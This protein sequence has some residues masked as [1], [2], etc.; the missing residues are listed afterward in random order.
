MWLRRRG[1]FSVDAD[2]TTSPSLAFVADT[3]DLCKIF[4]PECS[5]EALRFQISRF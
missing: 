2:K 1:M 4:F 3:S 5:V